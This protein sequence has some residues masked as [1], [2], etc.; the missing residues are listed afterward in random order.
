MSLPHDPRSGQ[1]A[2]RAKAIAIKGLQV[3]GT[4][5]WYLTKRIAQVIAWLWTKGLLIIRFALAQT[6]RLITWLVPKA[7]LT[8]ANALQWYETSEQM[9]Q[10]HRAKADFSERLEKRVIRLF[11]L[12][13]LELDKAGFTHIKLG[14]PS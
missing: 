6:D 8:F 10:W 9:Q 13:H 11:H 5:L 7:K 4:A 14:H 2:L 12:E 1:W 3:V